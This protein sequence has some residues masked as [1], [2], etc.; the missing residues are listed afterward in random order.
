MGL[1][2]DLYLNFIILFAL[3]KIVG[4]TERSLD[5]IFSHSILPIAAPSSRENEVR[6]L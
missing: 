2:G 1:Q 6:T 5:S 3:R 4:C